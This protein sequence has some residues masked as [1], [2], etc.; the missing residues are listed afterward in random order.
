MPR[1]AD[2]LD[3]GEEALQLEQRG[4]LVLGGAGEVGPQRLQAQPG[5]DQPLDER[6]R[7]LGRIH[8]RPV[9]AGVDLHVHADVATAGRCRQAPE[10][11]VRVQAGREAGVE[12]H[13]LGAGRE[14]RQHQDRRVDPRVAQAEPFLDEGDADPRG[15]GLER[16]A[17]HRDV[18]VSV[19]VGL[20]HRHQRPPRRASTSARCD[21]RR[22][23]RP[24]PTS[25]G[26]GSRVLPH[27]IHGLRHVAGDVGG[28]RPLPRRPA[29][30]DAGEAVHVRAR[31]RGV[32]GRHSPGEQPADDPR[33]HISRPGGGQ[34]R[35]AG[36]IRCARRRPGSPP[37][38]GSP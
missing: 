31:G 3:R 18:A 17:R 32:D 22:P 10:R 38:C 7:R 36:R 21:G 5:R 28:E 20:H 27:A 2:V 33:Q 14:L 4:L 24:R 6:R 26:A 23:G 16:G 8:A 12:G 25:A 30:G 13:G 1:G 34:D 19:R 9:H 11:P 37:A 15:A 29:R 35:A